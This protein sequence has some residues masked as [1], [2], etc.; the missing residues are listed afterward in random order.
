MV[1]LIQ[2]IFLSTYLA[3]L[4]V[5]RDKGPPKK[6]SSTKRNGQSQRGAALTRILGLLNTA[7]SAGERRKAGGG[8]ARHAGDRVSATL[9]G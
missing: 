6:D 7:V 5:Y 4:H 2:C 1:L 9:D 8:A 3:K